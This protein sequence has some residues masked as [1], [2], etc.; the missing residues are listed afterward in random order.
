[1]LE[2]LGLNK[3]ALARLRDRGLPC[4]RLNKNCRAYIDVDVIAWLKD[5]CQEGGETLKIG[6]SDSTDIASDNLNNASDSF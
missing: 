2:G 4:L 6:V 5:R 1:M 3:Q